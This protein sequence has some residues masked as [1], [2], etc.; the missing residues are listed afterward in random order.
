[1]SDLTPWNGILFET[2]IGVQVFKKF[3]PPP[4]DR[5]GVLKIPLWDNVFDQL[6]S[7]LTSPYFSEIYFSIIHPSAAVSPNGLFGFTN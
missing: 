2:T 5:Y 6:S 4:M 3:P 7:L 1:V